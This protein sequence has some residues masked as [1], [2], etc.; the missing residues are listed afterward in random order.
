M[1]FFPILAQGQNTRC[2]ELKRSI[3]NKYLVN[4]YDKYNI[5]FFPYYWLEAPYNLKA[6][7]IQE[8]DELF[9]LKIIDDVFNEY[10]PKLISGTIHSLFLLDSVTIDGGYT[11]PPVYT[12]NQVIYVSINNGVDKDSLRKKFEEGFEDVFFSYFPMSKNAENIINDSIKSAFEDCDISESISAE[13]SNASVKHGVTIKINTSAADLPVFCRQ[14]PYNNIVSGKNDNSIIDVLPVLEKAIDD[15]PEFYQNLVNNIYLFP[16][17]YS[18]NRLIPSFSYFSDIYLSVLDTNKV[19]VKD[20]ILDELRKQVSKIVCRNILPE[21][22]IEKWRSFGNDKVDSVYYIYDDLDDIKKN[23]NSFFLKKTELENC[24]STDIITKMKF[25]YLSEILCTF[26]HKLVLLDTSII[27]SCVVD[28]HE[29]FNV[30]VLYGFDFP[31]RNEGLTLAPGLS[32][33]SNP[34]NYQ[35]QRALLNLDTALSIYPKEMID[36]YLKNIFIVETMLFDKR[37][38]G[39]AGTYSYNDKSVYISNIGTFN[40]SLQKAFHHEFSSVVRKF[41]GVTF[42]VKE[43]LS[44]NDASFSYYLASNKSAPALKDEELHQQGFLEEYSTS[45]FDNDVEV[46]TSWL[47]YEPQKLAAVAKKYEKIMRKLRLLYNYYKA[48][49]G[50]ILFISEIEDIMK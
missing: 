34:N 39:P 21:I 29:K 43:W 23:F 49:D 32:I 46:F 9:V 36:R 35:M 15:Y 38:V 30:N 42:P 24:D 4:I 8:Q 16:G 11:F 18:N 26:T 7:N 40:S 1:V 10:P 3:E 48:V 31:I 12:Y 27:A 19:L 47:F 17:I 13:F 5:D 50:N 25:N 37:E 28:L 2:G 33:F 14:K 6:S 22:P 20:N 41:S 45:L 44:I